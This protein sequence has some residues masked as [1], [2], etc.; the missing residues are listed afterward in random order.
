MDDAAFLVLLGGF[1]I[2]NSTSDSIKKKKKI[3]RVGEST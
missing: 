2:S 1:V 3:K